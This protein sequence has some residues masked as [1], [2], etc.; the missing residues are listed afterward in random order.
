MEEA[1]NR[2][3]EE[4][5]QEGQ[6]LDLMVSFY[7]WWC[8][9][10]YSMDHY[11]RHNVKDQNPCRGNEGSW[12]LPP[13]F[14]FLWAL[15]CWSYR[16]GSCT[17]IKPLTESLW[18]ILSIYHHILSSCYFTQ[19]WCS[20]Y[21]A[22]LKHRNSKG[23]SIIQI[24]KIGLKT[25]FQIHTYAWPKKRSTHIKEIKFTLIHTIFSTGWES[26]PEA[27]Q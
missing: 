14:R 24:S 3:Q 9:W 17:V 1:C 2:Q 25:K 12:I 8:M 6:W 5:A 21:G 10:P 20:N 13:V 19:D 27:P 26:H 22:T 16:Q 23:E 4:I 7:E 15:W 11:V 18:S